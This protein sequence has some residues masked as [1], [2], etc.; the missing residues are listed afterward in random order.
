MQY[1]TKMPGIGEASQLYKPSGIGKRDSIP[2]SHIGSDA[3]SF[4]N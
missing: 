4:V 1:G 3:S 2:S